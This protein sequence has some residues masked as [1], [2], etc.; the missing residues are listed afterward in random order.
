M[1]K[2]SHKILNLGYKKSQTSEKKVT[3]CKFR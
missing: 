1:K 3:K 2:K